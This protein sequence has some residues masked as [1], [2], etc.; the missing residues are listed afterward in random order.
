LWSASELKLSRPTLA[1]VAWKKKKKFNR[2]M[3]EI[4]QEEEHVN[5]VLSKV[6]NNIVSG[7]IG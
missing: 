7:I 1:S 2:E 3:Y 5:N 6:S 4:E